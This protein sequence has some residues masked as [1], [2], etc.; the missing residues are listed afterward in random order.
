MFVFSVEG[1]K[2]VPVNSLDKLM[3]VFRH[4]EANKSVES[5][6]MNDRSSRSHAILKIIMERKTILNT[7]SDDDVYDK[8]N[9]MDQKLTV[10]A[11]S[12]SE[13][14]MKTSS[15]LNLVDFAGSE[16]VRHTGASKM[17]KNEGGMINKR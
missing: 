13:L 17:Q 2:E 11:P 4:G 5:T 9:V 1:L 16:S 8:E 14:V 15:A 10:G 7:K 12:S 6:K 3:D